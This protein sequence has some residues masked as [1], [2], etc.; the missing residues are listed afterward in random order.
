MKKPILAL[1]LAVTPLSACNLP[2]L[3]GAPPAPL[4]RT[5]V[6]D[7]ALETA[8]R[9][10]DGLLDA[11]AALTDAGVIQ[12]G[13]PAARTI[14]TAIRRVTRALGSAERFAAAGSATDYA[15][16]MQEALAGISE[17]RTAIGRP[18]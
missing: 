2:A 5:T 11:L 14:A 8:W 1:M 4:A 3:L 16:A 18:Q 6:D 17:I 15:T 12:P 10:W 9:A 7:R 13:T